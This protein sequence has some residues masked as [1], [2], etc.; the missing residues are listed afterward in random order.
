MQGY[1]LMPGGKNVLAR[2][3]NFRAPYR[4]GCDGPLNPS[5][6]LRKSTSLEI[7]PHFLGLLRG[8]VVVVGEGA[9]DGG[10]QFVRLGVGQFQRRHLLQMVVQEPGMVNQDL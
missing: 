3:I 5:K 1:Q 6:Y 8:G 4:A 7:G 9:D 2:R 10:S